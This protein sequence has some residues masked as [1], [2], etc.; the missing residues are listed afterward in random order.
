[1]LPFA[2]PVITGLLGVPQAQSLTVPPLV[3]L[4]LVA[5]KPSVYGKI[6]MGVAHCALVFCEKQNIHTNEIIIPVVLFKS[7][8][9]FNN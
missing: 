8:P 1:V 3:Q 6:F 5:S 4:P 9:K 2:A 7:N